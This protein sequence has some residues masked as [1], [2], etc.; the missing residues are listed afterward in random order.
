[1]LNERDVMASRATLRASVAIA[2]RAGVPADACRSLFDLHRAAFRRSLAATKDATGWIYDLRNSIADDGV[3]AM[4]QPHVDAIGAA[5]SSLSRDETRRYF[6]ELRTLVPS[7]TAAIDRLER[8]HLRQG[9]AKAMAAIPPSVQVAELTGLLEAID[10]LAANEKDVR[11]TLDAWEASVDGHLRE[12]DRLESTRRTSFQ[13]VRALI[14]EMRRGPVTDLRGR[15]DD[16][17]ALLVVGDSERAGLSAATERAIAA[18][19]GQLPPHVADSLTA[20]VN[21]AL[22]PQLFTGDADVAASLRGALRVGDLTADQR[23]ELEAIRSAYER[24]VAAAVAETTPL[25]ERSRSLAVVT[26]RHRAWLYAASNLPELAAEAESEQAIGTAAESALNEALAKWAERAKEFRQRIERALGRSVEPVGELDLDPEPPD[27]D[28]AGAEGPASAPRTPPEDEPFIPF[29]PR[30]DFERSVDAFP[31]ELQGAA[32]QIY[33]DLVHA[34]GEGRRDLMAKQAKAEEEEQRWRRE[35]P[36]EDPWMNHGNDFGLFEVA[37]DWTDRRNT[38]EQAFDAG[39]LSLL[40]PADARAWKEEAA[41]LRRGRVLKRSTSRSAVDLVKLLEGI[42]VDDERRAAVEEAR[43]AYVSD[44]DA[45][46]LRIERDGD[47]IIMRMRRNAT[48]S[49]Q[50]PTATQAKEIRAANIAFMRLSFDVR[51]VTELAVR[52]MADALGETSGAILI[53]RFERAKFPMLFAPSPAEIALDALR[54]ERSS[55]ELSPPVLERL[56]QVAAS[57][58]TSQERLRRL[59]IEAFDAWAE[60]ERALRRFTRPWDAEYGGDA[61]KAFEP[62]R[63][64]AAQPVIGCFELQFATIA[65]VRALLGEPTMARLPSDVRICLAVPGVPPQA[66]AR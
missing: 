49:G 21:R 22:Y 64:P 12:I 16:A 62:E 13:P 9:M 4:T 26:S 53:D 39:M 5:W 3:D 24:A 35:H 8:K 45:A 41:R 17:L 60:P 11:A 23:S 40:A 28:D 20:R 42:G 32:R 38:L 18:L 34:Y 33:D 6:A 30:A 47:A 61:P 63:N 48:Q 44:L 56:S 54:S 14:H 15:L 46:L 50:R 1:M 29:L 59:A 31:P 65:E 51:D 37:I 27:V 43:T 7:E 10:P 58:A 66:G 2:E 57:F 36:G 25:Y 52:R 55:S 19:R